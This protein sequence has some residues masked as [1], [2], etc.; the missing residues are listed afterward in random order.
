MPVTVLIR[1]AVMDTK[2]F[3]KKLAGINAN[4]DGKKR[5]ALDVWVR[6]DDCVAITGPC[7]FFATDGKNVIQ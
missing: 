2:S 3:I 4:I 6:K 7:P 5:P 1:V